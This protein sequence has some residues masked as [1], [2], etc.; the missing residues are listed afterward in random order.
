MS[1]II[2][3][4]RRTVKDGAFGEGSSAVICSS[5]HGKVYIFSTS[6]AD[7]IQ[8]LSQA[9]KTTDIQVVCVSQLLDLCVVSLTNHNRL[10]P[11]KNATASQ[12]LHL[13]KFPTS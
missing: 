9:G 6:T 10:H 2:P 13:P 8:V 12:A 3:T 4:K 5:N 7:P 1:Y 11:Q